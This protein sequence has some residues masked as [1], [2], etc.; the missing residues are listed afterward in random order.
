MSSDYP[1]TTL[2]DALRDVADKSDR[3]TMRDVMARLGTSS[4]S[5]IILVP[6][7]VLV[8][9]LS[10]I[11]TLP[12]IGAIV[13]ALA[14]VQWLAGRRHLWLPE[15]LLVQ[16]LDA[17]RLRRGLAWLD[18]PARWID[19]IT[20]PRVTILTKPPLNRIPLVLIL[21]CVLFWPLLELLPLVTTA[22]A[23]VVALFAF[24]I[25][26]RDGLFVLAGYVWAA[27]LATMALSLL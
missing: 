9:P 7:L 21:I 13:I 1:M 3:V 18:R 10:G 27:L 15:A 17:D 19:G 12:T 5:A 14:T 20:R 16:S 25:M 4:F 26:T 11:P 22:G 8:T 23:V 6:A 2:L 24:G